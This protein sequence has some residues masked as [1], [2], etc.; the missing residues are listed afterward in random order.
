[1]KGWFSSGHRRWSTYGGLTVWGAAAFMAQPSLASLFEHM[2][3]LPV[4]IAGTIWLAHH[5]V[6]T[7]KAHA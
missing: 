7:K 6:K 1:M 5:E 4:L 2:V 3:I